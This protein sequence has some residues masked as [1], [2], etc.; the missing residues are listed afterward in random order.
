M[1]HKKAAFKESIMS[2]PYDRRHMQT[3]ARYIIVF[4]VDVTRSVALFLTNTLHLKPFEKCPG[5][6]IAKKTLFCYSEMI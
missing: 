1:K 5:P 2:V 4:D 6:K 3:G